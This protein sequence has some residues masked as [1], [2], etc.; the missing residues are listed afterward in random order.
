MSIL[1][2]VCWGRACEC[3]HLIPLAQKHTA[4]WFIGRRPTGA[5]VI[6]V[7]DGSEVVRFEIEQCARTVYSRYMSCYPQSLFPL[8]HRI[9]ICAAVS[10]MVVEWRF[11]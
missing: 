1:N 2:F 3:I 4:I 10:S 9:E 8:T 11:L 5:V 7:V 6:H